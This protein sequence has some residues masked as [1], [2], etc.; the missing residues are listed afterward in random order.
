MLV[1]AQWL[2]IPTLLTELYFRYTLPVTVARPFAPGTYNRLINDVSTVTRGQVTVKWAVMLRVR[3]TISLPPA[4]DLQY[5][6]LDSAS[7]SN[8]LSPY[9]L[10]SQTPVRVH[11][12]SP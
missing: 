4:F 11:R 6:P 7:P 9:S 5:D 2:S 10:V 8:V 1:R 12:T 3:N